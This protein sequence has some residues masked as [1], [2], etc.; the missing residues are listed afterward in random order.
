MLTPCSFAADPADLQRQATQLNLITDTAN[1]LCSEIPLQGNTDVSEVSG[2]VSAEVHGLLK[3]L[4]DAGVEAQ[5]RIQKGSFQGVL[6]KDLVEAI[7]RNENC[8]LQV[9][10][11]LKDQLLPPLPKPQSVKHPPVNAPDTAIYINSGVFKIA[12]KLNVAV[13]IQGLSGT[14]VAPLE[15]SVRNALG[16]R[17]YKVV[18]VFTA[19]FT[20]A[21]M[22]RQLFDG[23]PSLAA[24]LKLQRYCDTV[25]LGMLRLVG[26]AQQVANGL[27]I[28]EAVLDIRAIDPVSGD[29]IGQTLEISE[30]GGGA[31]AQLSTENALERLKNSVEGSVREWSWT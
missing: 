1:K 9:L 25:L 5:G 20:H 29:V 3:K 26:P 14:D 22:G 11:E 21:G 10:S 31:D 7:S 23:D 13:S 28:R 17:G 12:G 2:K 24:R 4:A 30:K 6:Q 16:D 19:E 27:F 18:P 15:T 8:K